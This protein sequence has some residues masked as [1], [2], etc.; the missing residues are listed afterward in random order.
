MLQRLILLYMKDYSDSDTSLKS[1][2]ESD[3]ESP[4]RSDGN[5]D[6][7]LENIEPA[8]G[9]TVHNEYKNAP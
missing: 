4:P 7:L 3:Q 9:E 5:T 2:C 1:E 8:L 6:E